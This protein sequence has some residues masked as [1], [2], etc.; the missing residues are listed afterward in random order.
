VIAVSDLSVLST[1]PRGFH[2]ARRRERAA[3][4]ATY[5]RVET[6]MPPAEVARLEALC[7]RPEGSWRP[8]RCEVFAYVI[9]LGL[10]RAESIYRAAVKSSAAHQARR[11]A[12]GGAT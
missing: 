12:K 11:A 7:V 8:S 6:R 2:R 4:R 5:K 10:D 1:V 3:L 9:S